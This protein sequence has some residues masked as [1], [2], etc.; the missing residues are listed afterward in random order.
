MSRWGNWKPRNYNHIISFPK[1][2]SF[3]IIQ[4]LPNQHMFLK[5]KNLK[6]CDQDSNDSIN[7]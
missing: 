4:I 7:H 1:Y 5:I 6:F 2:V 3:K